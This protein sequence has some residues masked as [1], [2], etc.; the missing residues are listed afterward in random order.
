MFIKLTDHNGDPV[1]F[2]SEQIAYY[3]PLK[4]KK[5]TYLH[6]ANPGENSYFYVQESTEFLNNCLCANPC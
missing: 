4:S 1:T 6:L 3:L 2:N 5:G